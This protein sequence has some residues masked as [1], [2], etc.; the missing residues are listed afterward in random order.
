[1]ASFRQALVVAVIAALLSLGVIGELTGARNYRYEHPARA[2]DGLGISI[3]DAAGLDCEMLWHLAGS[4]SGPI[5]G[6]SRAFDEPSTMRSNATA[7]VEVS[8]SVGDQVLNV[9]D[10]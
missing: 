2:G 1:M 5:N 3:D 9:V 6:S 4:E 7:A 8:R 10:G